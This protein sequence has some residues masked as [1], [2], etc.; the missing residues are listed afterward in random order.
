[1]VQLCSSTGKNETPLVLI[2]FTYERMKNV[3]SEIK[4]D[5]IR[6]VS[7]FIDSLGAGIS[8]EV[9]FRSFVNLK[10]GDCLHVDM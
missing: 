5:F 10:F 3:L 1:M 4:M 2:Q 9:E 6:N 8:F 7:V